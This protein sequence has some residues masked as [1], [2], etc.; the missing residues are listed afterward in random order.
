MVGSNY[1]PLPQNQAMAHLARAAQ[2]GTIAAAIFGKQ[3]F[4]SMGWPVPPL[5]Q[6][7]DEG[8]WGVSGFAWFVGN[9]VQ[10]SLLKTGAF[11]IYVDGQQVSSKLREGQLPALDR[12]VGAVEDM[13][14][15]RQPQQQQG[16]FDG[17]G[18]AG[19]GAGERLRPGRKEEED[20][21]DDAAF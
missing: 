7:M 1:P 9:M 11:E 12:V 5:L 10:Q 14:R 19:A 16:A 20:E 18:G 6:Q 21:E 17:D 2:M 13:L 4:A 3:A 15:A 8:K